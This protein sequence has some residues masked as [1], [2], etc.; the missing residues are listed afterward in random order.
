MVMANEGA[1]DADRVT[2]SAEGVPARAVDST[3]P[4]ALAGVPA[5]AVDS[6]L[7]WSP[8][9]PGASSDSTQPWS[10]GAPGPAV[11]STLAWSAGVSRP[12]V[13]S[14]G[15]LDDQMTSSSRVF[16]EPVDSDDLPLPVWSPEAEVGFE[17]AVTEVT[18]AR[19]RHVSGL[20][21]RVIDG[22]CAGLSMPLEQD[23]VEIGRGQPSTSTPGRIALPEATLSHTQAT[24]RWSASRRAFELHPHALAKNLTCVAGTIVKKAT[25]VI[26]G[27]EVKMGLLS[28]VLEVRPD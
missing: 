8:G 17:T 9:V 21:L 22:V 18:P 14:T 24:L 6:T 15:A 19:Q 5:P 7:P 16:G 27:V 12:A 26:P 13:G 2:G 3:Q 25:T 1:A 4:W 10:A 20:R 28:F 23:V 11:D